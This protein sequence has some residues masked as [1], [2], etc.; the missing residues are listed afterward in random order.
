MTPDHTARDTAPPAPDDPAR[1]APGAAFGTGPVAASDAPAVAAPGAVRDAASG[2]GSDAVSGAASRTDPD[3]APVAASGTACGAAPDAAPVPGAVSGAGPGIAREAARATC[4]RQEAA[5]CGG[6]AAARSLEPD[7]LVAGGGV[8]GLTTALALYAA[9]FVRVTVVEAASGTRPADAGLTL[10]PDAARELDA[11]G[12][13]GR[14]EADA[15]RTRELRYYHRCGALVAREERGLRAGYRWPQLSVRRTHLQRVLADAVRERLGAGALVTGVRVTGVERP[16]G[17]ARPRVR[18]EHRSGGGVRSLSCLE[19]DLLIGADGVRSTVRSALHPD[20]DEPPGSGMLVWRGVSRMDARRTPPFTLVAGDDRQKA[21]VHPLTAPSPH[22]PEVLVGWTLALPADTA[23][24]RPP[25][26]GDRPVPVERLL[27]RYAGWEFDG[28]SL[29]EVL[30]AADGAYAHPVADRAPLARWSH[31]RTTL[32]GDAAHAAY[33]V[34]CG[35]ATR[36]VIDARALAHA[37]AVHPDPVEALAAYEAERRPATAGPRHA[38]RSP[39]PRARAHP[40][41]ERAPG[42]PTGIDDLVPP[43]ERHALTARCAAVG[44]P[45]R[46]AVNQGSPYDIPAPVPLP[47]GVPAGGTPLLGAP[48]RTPFAHGAPAHGLPAPGAPAHGAPFRAAPSYAA[49]TYGLS[50]RAAP[51]HDTPGTHVRP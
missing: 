12:L 36:S 37:L 19:P 32:V 4:A 34:E 2:A 16:P 27:G 29:P 51:L 50:A 45:D 22:R 33:P 48:G 8:A 40:A 24:E 13:L 31:G 46:E 47:P 42:G 9:G 39:G 41:H 35:G 5:E 17:G 26:D 14:L 28:V 7:V 6:A 15:V 44:V 25:G 49:P 11:L 20:E 30:R 10:M 38:G 1:P 43:E 21:V 3:A 23:G 18:I